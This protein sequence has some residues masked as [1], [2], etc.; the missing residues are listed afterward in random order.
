MVH[1]L[2]KA[3]TDILNKC[4]HYLKK[5]GQVCTLFFSVASRTTAGIDSRTL[6]V[7]P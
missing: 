2:D 7:G 3:K 1:D 4:A 6:G 5:L